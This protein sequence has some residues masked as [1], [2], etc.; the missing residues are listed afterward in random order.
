MAVSR[1]YGRCGGD[2]AVHVGLSLMDVSLQPL[3]AGL[4]GL[5]VHSGGRR[6]WLS[7]G[8]DRGKRGRGRGHHAPQHPVAKLAQARQQA[9]ALTVGI[10]PTDRPAGKTSHQQAR[11]GQVSEEHAHS[12]QCSLCLLRVGG[13]ASCKGLNAVRQGELMKR[14]RASADQSSL[15]ARGVTQSDKKAEGLRVSRA[16]APQTCRSFRCLMRPCH[17]ASQELCACATSH[18]TRIAPEQ[19]ATL[20]HRR[21]G[22]H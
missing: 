1:Q 18:A 16:R 19:C 9:S 17:G 10:A 15:L 21:Q 14:S 3:P 7:P 20:L 13:S 4:R 6:Q 5:P 2:L 11:Q 22:V 8:E 12:P